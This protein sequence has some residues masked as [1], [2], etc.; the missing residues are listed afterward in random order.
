MIKNFKKNNQQK[1]KL[2]FFCIISIACLIPTFV[3]ADDSNI[4]FSN[5]YKDWLKLS[6]EEQKNVP[7]PDKYL[8]NYK[9][10]TEY[11]LNANEYK[12]LLKSDSLPTYFDLRDVEGKNYVS[13][14]KNQ[15]SLAL[16]WAY[17]ATSVLESNL[18]LRNIG[19]YEFDPK[20]ISHASAVSFS[21]FSNPYGN[22]VLN[23]GGNFNFALVY[24]TSGLGPVSS[25][26]GNGRTA[27]TAKETLIDIANVQ[28]EESYI[29]PSLD[30]N[31]NPSY[32]DEYIKLIKNEIIKNGAVSFSGAAPL[33][34]S[35]QELSS[36]YKC[37][38]PHNNSNYSV[39]TDNASD[40]YCAEHAMVIV[41]WDDNFSKEKFN[42]G[43]TTGEKPTRD[44]AWIVKNSWGTIHGDEGYYYYSYEDYN[45]NRNGIEVISNTS[46]KDYDTIY[47]YESTGTYRKVFPNAEG[48]I[49][50]FDKLEQT[51]I[52]N[53]IS[54]SISSLPTNAKVDYEIYV[55]ATDGELETSKFNLVKSGKD[56]FDKQG[57]Y[58]VKLDTPIEL[59]GEQFVIAIKMTEASVVSISSWSEQVSQELRGSLPKQSYIS[60]N[61][62]LT[63]LYK[64]DARS[65]SLNIKAFTS[66]KEENN[67]PTLNTILKHTE[68]SLPLT[69]QVVSLK[70]VTKNI[71]G[72]TALSYKIKNSKQEDVISLFKL[73]KGIV[74][75]NMSISTIQI[76]S[77]IPEDKYIVETYYN[78]TLL[79]EDILYLQENVLE[80]SEVTSSPEKVYEGTIGNFCLK[81]SY[82]T[83][84]I[85]YK[86]E[87]SKN[88]DVTSAFKVTTTKINDEQTSLLI[89]TDKNNPADTYNIIVSDDN[90]SKTKPFIIY[91]KN[92]LV[93]QD[94]SSYIISEEENTQFI[95]NI[96][97]AKTDDEIQPLTK[98]AFI[99][100]FKTFEAEI[101][102]KNGNTKVE[103][104]TAIIKTGMIVKTSY[105][106]YLIVIK[107][108]TNGDGKINTVDVSKLYSHVQEK[109]KIGEEH[110][111]KAGDT[112]ND[113]RINAVDVS[114]LYSYIRNTI[115]SL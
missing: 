37:G 52:L 44:G 21:D 92:L 63:D 23:Q 96:L 29:L 81:S 73:E 79:D 54:F 108:D 28:V 15:G 49:N 56:V 48:Y 24:W 3:F 13:A 10:S 98:Q 47:Q 80:L 112:N 102:E 8:Q 1:N 26:S 18:M 94:T 106:N 75:N 114:K 11:I 35:R 57:Y 67:I 66:K 19:S 34:A 7:E 62:V 61:G 74:I 69:D 4:E 85:T 45:L 100:N 43:L 58:T 32:L 30:L 103:E 78:E 40:Y 60:T 68:I 90:Y 104:N 14:I 77:N 87:D 86:I 17:A 109:N 6:K 70:T 20:H 16:C 2:I 105:K 31:K 71:T 89:E 33:D 42:A 53:E 111:L 39:Y 97:L 83:A 46:T 107:G 82:Q 22:Q 93:L 9:P 91:T 95:E 59:T 101:Y 41:G 38:N 55:N 5:V 88:N 72:G 12:P 99:S 36:G 50:V 27:L 51:E 84:A 76:S 113:N 115:S 65:F 110:Y 64:P 25:F